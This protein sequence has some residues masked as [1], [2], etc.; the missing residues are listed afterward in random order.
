MDIKEQNGSVVFLVRV[1]PRSSRDAIEGEHGGAL[2]IRL[3]APPVDGRANDALR[4]LLAHS[5]NVPLGAVKIVAGEANRTKRVSVT[6][7]SPAQVLALGAPPR[8]ESR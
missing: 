2:K 3:T 5:L 4:R 8:K 6:G 1:S 7:V